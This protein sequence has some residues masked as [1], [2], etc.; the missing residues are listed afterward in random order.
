MMTKKAPTINIE[1]TTSNFVFLWPGIMAFFMIFYNLIYLKGSGILLYL[2][3]ALLLMIPPITLK[4]GRKIKVSNSK[5]Y[6]Y[7]R[8]KKV[9]SWKIIGD[10]HLITYKRSF[11]GK[12]FNYGTLTIVNNEK[13][14]FQ[15]LYL[16]DMP[17]VYEGIL[18]IYED[19]MKKI[20]PEFKL[21]EEAENNNK[22]DTLKERSE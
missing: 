17:E 2:L 3:I 12:I 15:Y 14:M 9:V 21:I 16:Q 19:G 4:R 6:L 5:I 7:V 11:L 1:K 20:D 8:H 18:K 10:F 13:E 22:L